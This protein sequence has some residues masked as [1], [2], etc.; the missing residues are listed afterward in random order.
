VGPADIPVLTAGGSCSAN[1]QVC[2]GLNAGTTPPKKILS[3]SRLAVLGSPRTILQQH[4]AAPVIHLS[5]P[6]R[7]R[8]SGEWTPA[9][10]VTF[11]VTLAASQS[12]TLAARAASMSRKAAYALKARDP[13]FAG[14]WQAALAASRPSRRQGDKVKEVHGPR[15][16]RGQ[17][18]RR[19]RS[20]DAELR[21]QFFSTITANRAASVARNAP[22][23]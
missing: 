7:S 2:F 10:A 22:L 13:A 5:R 12:V 18:N 6:R 16:S 21:D 4:E 1:R 14:A 3:Y 8:R 20:F 11:I 23:P 17:G 15:V 9:R 19:F